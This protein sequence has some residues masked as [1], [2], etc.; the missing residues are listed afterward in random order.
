MLLL[1]IDLGTSPIKVSV[2]DELTRKW[3]A[4]A[5]FVNATGVAV[6]LHQCDGSVG[7]ATG[8]GIGAGI[9]NE[10]D[11]STDT[12]ALKIIEPSQTDKYDELYHKW[13]EFL[14]VQLQKPSETNSLS[15]SIEL[16]N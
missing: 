12:K 13:K 15:Q 14:Q 16:T 8:A 6:E 3:I 9:F 4:S 11:L 7:A 2:V 5:Q 1:G 10:K